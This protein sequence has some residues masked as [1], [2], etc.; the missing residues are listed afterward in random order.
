M[1]VKAWDKTISS[2]QDR[3][4]AQGEKGKL[5][6]DSSTEVPTLPGHLNQLGSFNKEKAQAKPQ[7]SLGWVMIDNL[8][9][10]LP[11]FCSKVFNIDN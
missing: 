10:L 7:Q 9:N 2:K 8:K 1:R 11:K 4:G 5:K 6:P 3:R